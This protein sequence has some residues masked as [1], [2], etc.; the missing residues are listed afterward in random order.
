VYRA[1]LADHRGRTAEALADLR[2]AAV[3]VP[4]WRNLAWLA[5]LERRNGQTA[6]ARQHLRQ[7]L[8]RDPGNPWGL[9]T[10]AQIELAYGDPAHAETLYAELAAASPKERSLWTNLGLARFFSGRYAAAIDAYE[11][12]LAIDP[13]HN[14]VLLNLADCELALGR[15][16]AAADHY[17]QALARLE[18]VEAKAGLSPDD[19]MAKAQCLAQLGRAS[20]AAEL[21]QRTL[22]RRPDE[23]GIVYAAALVYALVG[24]RTSARINARA[25]LHQGFGPAW[26]RIAAFD[27]LRDD[28]ELRS[29]L[30]ARAFP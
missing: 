29:L 20:E 30:S 24:D 2:A 5:D 11:K 6:E 25:A 9:G 19:S 15:R 18:Q 26:F 3:R 14:T 12:A 27:S 22:Q 21:A 13:L 1:E 28:P 16:Q 4:S 7:L 23:P 8:A 17:R 10:L